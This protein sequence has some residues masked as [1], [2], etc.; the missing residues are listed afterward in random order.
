LELT[1]YTALMIGL[2]GSTHCIGMC[3]GIVGALNIGAPERGGQTLL[4][5]AASPFLYNTGRILSYSVAGALAG[6]IGAQAKRVSPHS[7][8]PLGAIIA[9]LFMIALG[10]YLAGW[11]RAFG[12]IDKA[13]LFV[14]RFI[15][16]AGKRLLPASTPLHV[17]GLGLVWGWLPCGLV[18]SAL[19]LAVVSASPGNGALLMFAF[20]LGTLPMLLAM[21]HFARRLRQLVQ[22]PV[23]RRLAGAII[24]LFGVYTCVTAFSSHGR[25]PRSVS[26]AD[27]TV[28]VIIVQNGTGYRI[29][30]DRDHRPG[31]LR[32][33]ERSTRIRTCIPAPLQRSWKREYSFNRA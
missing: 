9:G 19:A 20:G 12:G 26:P 15:A 24:V 28:A 11:W 22:Y 1:F 3:G 6:A 10:F 18:Y 30:V 16:P 23:V 31:V 7:V 27:G 4:S 8:L 25:H 14:W 32:R 21:G 17:F 5:R 33:Y 29:D 2:L 13:G